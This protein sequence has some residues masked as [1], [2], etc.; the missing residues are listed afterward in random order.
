M[1]GPVVYR[2]QVEVEVEV[3]DEGFKADA[4]S[5]LSPLPINSE[6]A[7][8]LAGTHIQ[9]GRWPDA[10]ALLRE[11][12]NANPYCAD[13]CNDL[14]N[15]LQTTGRASE[16]IPFYRRALAIHPEKPD[17]R[18]NLGLALRSVGKTD[19]AVEEFREALRLAPGDADVHYNLALTLHDRDR[20]E[21]AAAEY[22]EAIRLRPRYA[23]AHHNLG[24][25][26]QRM[27]RIQEAIG[28]Y[29]EAIASDPNF[30]AAHFN[31]GNLFRAFKRYPEAVIEYRMAARLAP[32]HADA[33]Y[34]L[35]DVLQLC[36]NLREAHDAYLQALAIHSQHSKA[37][38]GLGLVFFEWGRAEEAMECYRRSLYIEPQNADAQGNLAVVLA[39][40]GHLDE[41]IEA[42][43]Q[44]VQI[45]PR[46][47][48]A[49]NNLGNLYGMQGRLKLAIECYAEALKLM[50]HAEEIHSNFLFAKYFDPEADA[51]KLLAEA[52]RWNEVHA[53]RW[54][55]PALP[56]TREHSADKRLRIG[57]VSADFC[58]HVVGRCLLP[59][60]RHCDPEGF[61]IIC[62]SNVVAP[63]Q[64]TAELQSM[65]SE[66]RDIVGVP[67]DDAA[68]MIK[69]DQ[70]DILVDLAV[71][72]A[73][74]RLPIFARKPAPIQ[75]TFL[76]Y[77]GTTGLDAM[78][79]RFSDPYFDPPGSDLKVYSEK[80]IRLRSFWCYMPPVPTPDVT[81]LPALAS[82]RIT[83][84][85]LNQFGK[86]SDA[87]LDL[88][89]EL[90]AEIPDSQF[91]LNSPHGWCRQRVL[92]HAA[93]KGIVVD[94]FNFVDR[95]PVD[96]YFR[97]WSRVDVALDP[98]PYGGGIT[99]FDALWMG[100]PVLTLEGRTAVG[101]GGCSI[102]SQLGM[103][104][105][106]AKNS[107]DY[108]PAAKRLTADHCRLAELR[109][110][111]RA[112]IEDSSLRDGAAYAR[113]VEAAYRKIWQQW[114]IENPL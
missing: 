69:N 42:C 92:Q 14:A 73:R 34:K 52:R 103:S 98:F 27:G 25:A 33:W 31:L 85:C 53:S 55:A 43:R 38:N 10:E 66:W 29:R 22:R 65:A 111:L 80:T 71:H 47:A 74:N 109:R 20:V 83:F 19:E 104:D 95:Q 23:A 108:I 99:T 18:G 17:F 82:N 78:D 59:L 72:T 46:Y 3:E 6:F 112:R 89:C 68:A 57:Y 102:L 54:S 110:E 86:V 84:G 63:D 28:A 32:S 64:L 61:E 97:T 114:C 35:G 70:I 45:N 37:Y 1:R 44:A 5:R 9:N 96:H 51:A 40:S 81:E 76:G 107:A 77:C 91:L 79:Y 24:D 62:Y 48:A 50:P 88:W 67:D 15:V 105:W 87:A 21:D 100:V 13:A 30:A 101:R 94:R 60:L 56:R 106:I 58:E 113:D 4:L 26:L 75:V 2:F 41:A 12:L 16:S 8:R 93:A 36:G 90:L 11:I 49:I 7:L 39:R